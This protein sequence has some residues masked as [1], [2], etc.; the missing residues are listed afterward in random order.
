VNVYIYLEFILQQEN[1]FHLQETFQLSDISVQNM[2][3]KVLSRVY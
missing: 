2:S 1:T 3:V